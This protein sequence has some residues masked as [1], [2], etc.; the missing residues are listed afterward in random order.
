MENKR[1]SQKEREKETLYFDA[2]LILFVQTLHVILTHSASKYG[3]KDAIGW[4]TMKDSTDAEA[5]PYS[6]LSYEEFCESARLIGRGL[7]RL[8]VSPRQNVGIL[9]ET[10][11]F[12]SVS[13]YGCYSQCVCV[14]ALPTTLG[15]EKI[16]SALSQSDVVAVQTSS[17]MLTS[18]SRLL[19]Q[20]PSVKFVVVTDPA[21]AGDARIHE[22]GLRECGIRI[23][24]WY[25]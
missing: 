23:Y 2:H 14:C 5:G 7:R 12:W 9:H 10:S 18:L 1:L 16:F 3:R 25:V 24:S 21:G 8:G 19:I 11:H 22:A 6:W 15:E 17:L 13:A 4:R 20:I